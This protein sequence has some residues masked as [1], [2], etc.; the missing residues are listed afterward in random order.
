MIKLELL[1]DGNQALWDSLVAAHEHG[2]IFHTWSW[3][4]TC[5]LLYQAEKIPIGIFDGPQLIGVIPLIRTRRK[6]MTIL[7]SPLGNVGY[8]GPLI[9]S[10]HYREVM[11]LFEGLLK[12]LG[13][14]YAEFRI[15]DNPNIEGIS[16]TRLMIQELKTIVVKLSTQ[17]EQQWM[18]LESRC[19][20][21][22]S[23]AQRENVDIVIATNKEFLEVYYEMVKETYGRSNRPPPYSKEY[24]ELMW[25]A[26][27]PAGKIQAFLAQFCGRAIAG[28]IVLCFNRGIWGFDAASFPEGRQLCANNLLHWTIMEWGAS[29]GLAEYDLMG[30]N[31]PRFT[32]FKKSFGGE[33]RPYW[34]VSMDVTLLSN[35]GRRF[36]QRIVPQ[37]RQLKFKI[38]S[39]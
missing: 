9:D 8:G 21:A 23:K 16:E 20:R 3:M 11:M 4:N 2:T 36:Y 1:E 7:A 31:T 14:D 33:V 25:D 15:Q 22:V 26:L 38:Q 10:Q 12:S 37:M 24:Y 19:R 27:R 6:L 17:N 13:A 28:A 35:F 39:V 32:K 30:A 29:N 34:C 5:E 18:N